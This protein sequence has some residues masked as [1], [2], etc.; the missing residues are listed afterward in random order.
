MHMN[1][2][3]FINS[4][5]ATLIRKLGMMASL[6]YRRFLVYLCLM[7]YQSKQILDFPMMRPMSS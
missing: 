7:I 5:L 2:I 6:K 4:N 1:N 3:K